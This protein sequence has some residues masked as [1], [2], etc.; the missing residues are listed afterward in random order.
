MFLVDG[1]HVFGHARDRLV[2]ALAHLARSFAAP[3]AVVFQGVP[4]PCPPRRRPR[5]RVY[6][7]GA[8]SSVGA[9]ILDLL[10]LEARASPITVVT[11]DP[12]LAACARERGARGASMQLLNHA[13]FG[14][15]P[16]AAA[17]TTWSRPPRF[18]S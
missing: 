8:T 11:G 12:H 14:A 2:R 3:S 13:T 1:S 5:V 18:A 16:R 15:Y 10:A 17:S 6:F 7:A 4:G 9:R